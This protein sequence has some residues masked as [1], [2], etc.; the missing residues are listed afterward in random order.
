MAEPPRIKTFH[1]RRGRITPSQARGLRD[2]AARWLLVPDRRP[3]DLESEFGPGVPVVLEIGF[4][5]GEATVD[6]ASAEPGRG[7]L[8]VD[9][10]TP[11]VGQ[12]L[13]GIG[14]RGLTNVRV[15]QGD[16]VEVVQDMIAPASLSGVRI[17][18]PDPWPKSRHHK[19]RL[20]QPPFVSLLCS[21]MAPGA[22]LHCATDWLPYAEQM[23][24]VL[25]ASP[26]LTRSSI[27]DDDVLERPLARPLTRFEQRG[28]ARGHRV[29][30]LV[31]TRTLDT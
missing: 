6:L 20:V 28:I 24:A 5:M 23:V 11:G 15:M 17:F 3:L 27:R 18:F 26:G 21:R 19:R 22:F 13:A 7:V 30:D 12:L 2:H 31:F 10:H 25:S 8:A 16:A 1:P 9:V 29:V 14:S 4:G